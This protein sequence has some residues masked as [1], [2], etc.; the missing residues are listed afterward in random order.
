[1]SK[2]PMCECIDFEYVPQF[3]QHLPF[4][5]VSAHSTWRLYLSN[6][7]ST[8]HVHEYGLVVLSSVVFAIFT[9][10]SCVSIERPCWWRFTDKFSIGKEEAM[11][12]APVTHHYVAAQ[13]VAPGPQGSRVPVG[14]R[15]AAFLAASSSPT[16][17]G[18]KYG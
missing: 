11:C 12:D 10:V 15:G 5:C 1:M 3:E 13:G 8:R 2:P 14:T 18:P 17:N 6:R 4:G 9:S 7:D 16:H